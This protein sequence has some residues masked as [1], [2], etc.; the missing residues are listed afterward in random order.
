LVPLGVTLHAS[1]FLD[2]GMLMLE[3]TKTKQRSKNTVLFYF[4]TR[5]KKGEND[6][7]RETRGSQQKPRAKSK[8]EGKSYV[9]DTRKKE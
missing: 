9:P 1:L 3:N 2:F 4:V 5:I 8:K 6:S 7:E